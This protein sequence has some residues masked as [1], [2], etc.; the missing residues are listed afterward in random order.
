MKNEHKNPDRDLNKD[1]LDELS[2]DEL[3]D[4]ELDPVSGGVKVTYI[5]FPPLFIKAKKPKPTIVHL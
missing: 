3:T 5:E 2:E 1:I 4:V